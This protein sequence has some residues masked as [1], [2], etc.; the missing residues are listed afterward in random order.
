MLVF[1]CY[2]IVP[3][4][5][6]FVLCCVV[7]QMEVVVLCCVVPQFGGHYVYLTWRFIDCT[8]PGG[9]LFLIAYCTS[10]GGIYSLEILPRHEV[11]GP[12]NNVSPAAPPFGVSLFFVRY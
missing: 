6:V 11:L 4:L 10:P 9:F 1:Y 7:P 8:S 5:E 2:C 12:A 3:Q